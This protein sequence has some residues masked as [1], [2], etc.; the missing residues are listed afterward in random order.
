ML[1]SNMS[2]SRLHELKLR[3]RALLAVVEFATPPRAPIARVGA[4]RDQWTVEEELLE[5]RDLV[6]SSGVDV[7][8][9]V[10][11]HHVRP[12]PR[13]VIGQGKVDEIACAAVAQQATC[14]IF[15]INLSP[16][17][18][19][20]LERVIGKKTIDRTQLILDIFAQRA[21]SQEG[22]IQVELAQLEYMLPRLFGEGIYLSRLAGGIGTRGPGEQKI[23]TD[24]R[25][26]RQRVKHLKRDLED[27][28]RRRSAVRQKRVERHVPTM[29][30]VGYTNA[31]KT[32]LFNRLT[33]ESASAQE[34]L[35]TTL[36]PLARR[37]TLPDRQ[38]V[39]L[40][41]TVG[42]LHQLPHNL[43][44]A[45]T[46][47]LEET[48]TATVLLCVL[49]ASHPMV[50]ERGQAVLDVLQTLGVSLERCVF[51][52]NKVDALPERGTQLRAL[53]REFGTGVPISAKQGHGL[54]RLQEAMTRA[55]G[56]HFV[57]CELQIPMPDYRVLERLYKEGEVLS[58]HYGVKAVEVS[59]RI[60]LD[61]KW[62]Y[63]SY[64][65]GQ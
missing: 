23:E 52:F 38:T 25:H 56:R 44:E 13:F 16:A 8:G 1:T 18:Q 3:E 48:A 59:A 17:Q 45:F 47:T 14:V 11:C 7:T 62:M 36:D 64:L 34:Q 53:E 29:A 21:I 31:G 50:M 4:V 32:T 65:N 58:V 35:F 42:F 10:A 12:H 39:V 43:I 5:L 28:S 41:D 9:Q 51:V 61:S 37:I 24:R 46:A 55:L 54:D 26:I 27:V 15:N 6:I 63:E 19:R 33:G 2:T 57:I 49:D 30:L 20:N 22:K 60:P 40:L